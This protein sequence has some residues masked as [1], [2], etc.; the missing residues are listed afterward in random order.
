MTRRESGP[1]DLLTALGL[2]LLLASPHS[3]GMTSII[4]CATN[5]QLVSMIAAAEFFPVGGVHGAGAGIG[6]RWAAMSKEIVNGSW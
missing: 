5:R 6:G 3:A 4:F 2:I 1:M